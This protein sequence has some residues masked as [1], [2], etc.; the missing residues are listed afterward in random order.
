MAQGDANAAAELLRQYNDAVTDPEQRADAELRLAKLLDA[1]GDREGAIDALDIV[2]TARPDDLGAREKLVELLFAANNPGRAADELERLAAQRTEAPARAR[3][4]LRAGRLHR[5]HGN[6]VGRARRAFERALAADPLNLDALRDLAE[7]VDG[8]ARVQMLEGATAPVRARVAEGPPALRVLAAIAQLS[9]DEALGYAA[10]GA[11]VALGAANDEETRRH[12][13]DRQRLGAQPLRPRR[14]LNDEEWRGRVEH[15]G[16]RS[17]LTEAWL[18]VAESAARAGETEAAALGFA[19]GDRIA[20]RAVAKQ[21]P[22][23][24]AAQ[25]LIG[26]GEIDLYV[27]AGRTTFARTIG[28][29]VPLVLLS[30]DVARGETLEAR[31]LLGRTMA[32]ARLRSAP[33]EDMGVYDLALLIAAGIKVA[34][35]DPL[36]VLQ[37]ATPLVG[38]APRLEERARAVAKTLGRKDRKTLAGIPDRLAAVDLGAWIAAVRAT[39]RRAALLVCGD[40]P[41]ALRRG[42]GAPPAGA[43]PVALDVVAWS[44]SESCLY[45]RKDLGL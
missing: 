16:L 15:P 42:E 30:T 34:G 8:Q 43:D 19:R 38:H 27:T 28:L 22:A 31:A 17:P 10:N 3:D 7:I 29:E 25:R 5:D 40:V 18:A 2:L 39:H 26:L 35:A 12:A 1:L 33:I 37:L 21:A 45:L 20:P 24:E 6:D 13:A 41:I 36:R 44:V 32:A 23:V 9:G 14:A 11:L 4:D